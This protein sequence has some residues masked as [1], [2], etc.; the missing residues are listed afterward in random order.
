MFTNVR[1]NPDTIY[2]K[3]AEF[4]GTINDSKFYSEDMLDFLLGDVIPSK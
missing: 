1:I 4:S 3:P 2:F